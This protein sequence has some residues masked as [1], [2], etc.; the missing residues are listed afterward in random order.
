VK[1]NRARVLIVLA[2]IAA[3]VASLV[4]ASPAF[5]QKHSSKAST[6]VIWADHSRVPAVTKVANAWGAAHGVTV[7]VIEKDFG[8][9]RDTLTT[10]DPSTAPDVVVGANDWTGQLAANGLVVPLF[11]SKTV[12]ASFPKYALGAFSYGTAVK[13]LYGIPT[14]L[15]NIALIVNTKLAKVPT[16]FA[17]LEQEAVAFHKKGGGRLGIAVQQGTNGDAY[18]MYPF[19][20]GLCGYV[21]G[22]N[23]AGNLDPSAIGLRAPAFLKNTS[24]IDRWNKEG[25]INSKVDSGIAQSAFLKGKAAFWITG[26]WNTATLKSSGLKYRIMQ[27][28]KIACPSVPFL[29]VQGFFVTKFAAVHGV[30]AGARDLVTNFMTTPSAQLDLALANQRYPANI[31]AGK[32]VNDPVLAAFGKAGAGGV[33]LPNIPQMSSVWNDFGLAWVKST[34][35]AGA[36][37]A[38]VAF[39]SAARAIAS[40]I[41]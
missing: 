12:L 32:K 21:F 7:Q 35:G 4:A 38:R 3:I 1:A 22:T 19:F 16:T 8:T 28:P 37:S 18:H 24:M 10:V 9:I 30:D 15:E 29:G 23:S 34:K 11:P 25:L 20:S 27:V 39:S 2:T 33:P 31:A 6:L 14:Q 41:G 26:P 5:S 40:K 17:Q 36:S 13:K